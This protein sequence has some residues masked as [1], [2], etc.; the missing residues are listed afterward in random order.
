M[1]RRHGRIPTP[2]YPVPPAPPLPPPPPAPSPWEARRKGEGLVTPQATVDHRGQEMN[3]P[4]IQLDNPFQ[5]KTKDEHER[6]SSVR[7]DHFIMTTLFHLLYHLATTDDVSRGE[8]RREHNPP[9]G[10]KVNLLKDT[11]SRTTVVIV[12][13]DCEL[14]RASRTALNTRRD[15]FHDTMRRIQFNHPIDTFPASS[16]SSSTTGTN[17]TQLL[18]AW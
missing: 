6:Q 5:A 2:L 18:T 10:A 12:Q 4:E 8:C 15:V 11:H 3:S 1:K 14:I 7:Y 13:G 17:C 16:S 9:L